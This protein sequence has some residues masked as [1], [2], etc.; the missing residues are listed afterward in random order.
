[1]NEDK[2]TTEDTKECKNT[3]SDK[4][5]D[6]DFI[7]PKEFKKQI[8][9]FYE[10][11]AEIPPDELVEDLKLIAEGLSFNWR[12]IKYTQTWKEDMIGDAIIK[13]FAALKKKQFNIESSYNPFSYFNTIAW[14]A[15]SNRIKKENRQHKGLSEYRQQVYEEFMSDPAN[16]TYSRP[17]NTDEED[18]FEDGN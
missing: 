12:F 18:F 14:N 1:M 8:V 7:K 2:P 17:A 10:S 13:M 6:K 4:D 3:N 16:Q 15:F 9:A 5:K 11:G